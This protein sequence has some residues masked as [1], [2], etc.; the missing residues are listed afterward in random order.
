[1][2]KFILSLMVFLSSAVYADTSTGASKSTATIAAKCYLTTQDSV[3]R[4]KFR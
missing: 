1:M 4:I 2:K 3:G